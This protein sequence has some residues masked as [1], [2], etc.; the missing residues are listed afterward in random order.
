LN[1]QEDPLLKRVGFARTLFE[2]ALVAA[3]VFLAA[4][5]PAPAL[6]RDRVIYSVPTTEKVMALTYD[7]GPHPVFTPQLLDILDKYHVK[8]TFFMIGKSMEAHPEIV[9]EVIRRGHVI[10]N[11][12]Y[13]HPRNIDLDTQA[14]VIREL[15]RCEQLIERLTGS[16][17]HLFRP[18]RGMIDGSVFSV[19]D[20]E[21]YKT[22]LW[23]VCADHHDA[24]TPQLMAQRVVDHIRPGGIILAHDGSVS[25]RWRDIAA[26]PLIIEA[27]RRR[28]YRFVTVPELLNMK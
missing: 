2:L 1:R 18:P 13:S 28:G 12:T 14:Q 9:R 10:G 7:D 17:A 11:H 23:S 27:L 26:T 16:R 3:I 15:D 19:A 8:A 24:L 4:N 22:I 6:W 20:E 25:S 21:G 5:R